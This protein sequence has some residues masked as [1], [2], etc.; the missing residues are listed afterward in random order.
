MGGGGGNRGG[1]QKFQFKEIEGGQ[2]FS[3]PVNGLEAPPEMLAF[4]NPY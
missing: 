2:K 1:G 4:Q 3:P